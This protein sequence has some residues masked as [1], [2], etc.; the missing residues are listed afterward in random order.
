MDPN[1]F[2]LDMERAGEVLIAIVLLS[3]F[4]ERALAVL[5]E[6]RPF[7]D[8]TEEGKFVVKMENIQPGDKNHDK[9]L[10]QKKKK[11]LKESISFIVSVAVCWALHF[12]SGDETTV[13]GYIVTG[14]IVAGG[15]KASIKLFKDWMGFRSSAETQLQEARNSTGNN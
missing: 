9:I 7:I 13:L 4:I 10:K 11:G 14:A 6:S 1:L 8:R 5:F 2:H 3:F 12:A 15:S